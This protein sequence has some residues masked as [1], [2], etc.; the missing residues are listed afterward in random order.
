MMTRAQL[1]A[2]MKASVGTKDP[3]EF[4]SDM[5]D[6]FNMMFDRMESLEKDLKRVKTQSA[7]AIEWE[8]KVA[9][10]MI[11]KQVSIMRQDMDR[12]VYA[13]E[14]A[15]LKKAFAEDLVTQNY[16]SFCT[17]WQDTLG[18]HPFLD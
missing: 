6:V 4:F 2:K 9:S 16:N 7:L 14:I 11:S 18:W 5:V 13:N 8:P 1:L 10:D 3:L 15:A 17:F 12:D